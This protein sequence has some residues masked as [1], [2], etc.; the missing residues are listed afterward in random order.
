[1][2][3]SQE[4]KKKKEEEEERKKAKLTKNKVDRVSR[5]TTNFFLALCN[6]ALF[7]DNVVSVF[8][9]ESSV[10]SYVA[11]DTMSWPQ[12]LAHDICATSADIESLIVLLPLRSMC[13]PC[14]SRA[15]GLKGL[16]LFKDTCYA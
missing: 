9:Y 16:E 14:P 2:R 3:V 8:K 1:M 13:M 7:V 4:K 6:R 11:T 15:R 5:N 10:R 12:R